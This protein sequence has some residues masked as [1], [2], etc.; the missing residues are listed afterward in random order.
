MCLMISSVL[1]L[2]NIFWQSV[3]VHFGVIAKR[4]NSLLITK[5][6]PIFP[7]LFLQFVQDVLAR[8]SC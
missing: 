4:K 8:S 2:V 5:Y 1:L 7:T 3:G 6:W